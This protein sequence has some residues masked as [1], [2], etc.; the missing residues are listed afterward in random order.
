MEIPLTMF[1]FRYCPARYLH[2]MNMPSSLCHIVQ[3]LPQW[4]H[5]S[6]INAWLLSELDLEHGFDNPRP[7]GGLSLYDQPTLE[8]TLAT[9]GGLLHSQD[10]QQLIEHTSLQ[11]VLR[12]LGED[13]HRYCLEKWRLIIG[14]WPQGWQR[15]LPEGELDHYLPLCGLAFWLSA[16]GETDP[17]FARRL[18]LRLPTAAQMPVW[19]MDDEKLDLARALCL[20]VARERSPACCHLLK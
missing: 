11:R 4:R 10:I 2:T 8:V 6:T 20:K 13:G 14:Q 18:A 1:Q 17:G 12:V 15:P 7:L 19:P 9:L 5:D 16:C 3:A